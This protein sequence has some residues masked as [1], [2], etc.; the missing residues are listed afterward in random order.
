MC[1]YTYVFSLFL[2]PI[3]ILKIFISFFSSPSLS[4]PFGLLRLQFV[5][6][7]ARNFSVRS[8]MQFLLNEI[9][10]KKK[11]H[12]HHFS[13]APVC[14]NYLIPLTI[15]FILDTLYSA[16]MMPAP[17][18]NTHHIVNLFFF[19][20]HAQAQCHFSRKTN[21]IICMRKRKKKERFNIFFWTFPFFR[22]VSFIQFGHNIQTK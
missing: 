17:I 4:L 2:F 6:Y 3:A 12:L 9:E 11:V 19:R 15:V 13:C 10:K 20:L 7:K 16:H 1:V 8:D 21:F 14:E 5:T 22:S 18:H